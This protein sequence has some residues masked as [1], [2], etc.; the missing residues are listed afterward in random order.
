MQG[1]VSPGCKQGGLDG[2]Q[3]R[4]WWSSR[5][6]QESLPLNCQILSDPHLSRILPEGWTETRFSYWNNPAL[7]LHLGSRISV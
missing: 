7:P 1:K 5:D 6:A 4:G 3:P 2:D